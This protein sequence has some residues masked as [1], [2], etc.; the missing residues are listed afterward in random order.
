MTTPLDILDSAVKIGL[1]ALISG[2]ATFLVTT[3]NHAQE[4]R[5]A[6][7]EDKR[8][9]LRSV[10]KLVEDATATINLATYAYQHDPSTRSDSE[11]K[12]IGAVNSLGEAKSLAVLLGLKELVSSIATV[13][14]GVEHLAGYY[15]SAGS[16]YT[17]VE[18]NRLIAELGKSMPA[19]HTQLE[20]GYVS[21]QSDA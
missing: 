21:A 4:N 8:A 3:R 18:A 17:A 16:A 10:A 5:K 2:V 9:L 20:A 1:G 11:R 19:V 6:A 12:L 14:S 7:R 15:L 13:R